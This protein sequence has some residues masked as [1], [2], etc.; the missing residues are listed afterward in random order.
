MHVCICYIHTYCRPKLWDFIV[1]S[2]LANN[3]FSGFQHGIWMQILHHFSRCHLHL[4]SAKLK[5]PT[6]T[7][8]VRVPASQGSIDHTSTTKDLWMSIKVTIFLSD[9]RGTIMQIY[10]IYAFSSKKYT[11]QDYS[12]R[13]VWQ[14]HF[15]PIA[16]GAITDI[17]IFHAE[18]QHFTPLV[19]AHTHWIKKNLN[20]YLPSSNL[21]TVSESCVP[22][23]STSLTDRPALWPTWRDQLPQLTSALTKGETKFPP[24]P[25][26]T[27]LPQCETNRET[28]AATTER[29]AFGVRPIF[30]SLLTKFCSFQAF[31]QMAIF[32]K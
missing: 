28:N 15:T 13:F 5:A 31:F 9:V 22:P 6:T 27:N 21:V 7:M 14:H 18:Y 1:E 3:P 26:Q 2:N 32:A 16:N 30:F 29:L 25:P 19:I 23:R 24:R 17:L 10:D 12:K 11:K 20:W 4:P 8:T